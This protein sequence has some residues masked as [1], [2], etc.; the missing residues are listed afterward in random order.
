MI[1]LTDNKPRKVLHE[2]RNY[3]MGFAFLK[4]APKVS[5]FETVQPISPCK[6]YLNDVVW[7]EHMDAPIGAYGLKYSKQGIFNKKKSYLVISIMPTFGMDSYPSMDKDV[8]NL[9]GNIENL[10]TFINFFDDSLGCKATTIQEIEPNKYLVTM[11]YKWSKTTYAI[12]LFTLL[13][14]VGQFYKGTPNPMAFLSNFTAFPPDTYLLTD[15]L[16]RI[17]TFIKNKSLPEQDLSA[18]QE[19]ITIHNCGILAW[20]QN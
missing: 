14:R 16:P 20:Q 9:K 13:L 4:K 10:Q 8:A 3:Q 17:K 6:D 12:S 5:N 19:H 18:L 2:G 11:D 15:A 1:T 7:S